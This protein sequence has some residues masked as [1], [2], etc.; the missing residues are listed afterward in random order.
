MD[1][2]RQFE[3]RV[4]RILGASLLSE[5]DLA[6]LAEIPLASIERT[7][8][9]YFAATRHPLLPAHGN[10]QSTPMVVGTA[11]DTCVGFV[12]YVGDH[13]VTLECHVWG[14]QELP[15]SFR[16]EDVQ[17]AIVGAAT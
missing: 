12:A 10:V 16:D 8:T 14:D 13:E 6:A 9:G 5:D 2:F 4:L 15:E 17:I 1:R 7:R 3:I 11:R